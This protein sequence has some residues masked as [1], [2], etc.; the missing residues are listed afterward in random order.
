MPRN[1]VLTLIAVHALAVAALAVAVGATH[2]KPRP[3]RKTFEQVQVGMTPEEVE[4]TVGGP[5]GD[6]ISAD[7]MLVPYRTGLWFKYPA[8]WVSN[9]DE[10]QVWY[11]DDGRVTKVRIGPSRYFRRPAQY[12]R[13]WSW[14]T[15]GYD[16]PPGLAGFFHIGPYD[17]D[18]FRDIFLP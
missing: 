7:W 1:L 3:C 11:A 15:T 14:L 6:Y 4:A 8:E 13:V 16:S 12:E 5:P 17:L 9:G 2:C 18:V 10:L